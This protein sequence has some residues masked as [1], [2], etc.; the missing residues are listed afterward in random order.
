MTL[1]ARIASAG[2]AGATY[3][4]SLLAIAVSAISGTASQPASNQPSAPIE[5]SRRRIRRQTRPAAAT[6]SRTRTGSG[7]NITS[8][9]R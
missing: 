2:A 6:T 7:K 4:G 1:A 8:A 5:A 3:R 9:S